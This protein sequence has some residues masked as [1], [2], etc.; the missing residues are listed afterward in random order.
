MRRD[1]RALHVLR[2]A[3]RGEEART[4]P[5]IWSPLFAQREVDGE[6][7]PPMDVLALLPDHRD[8]RQR[9]DAQRDQRRHAR[10]HREPGGAAQ[11]AGESGAAGDAPSRRSCAGSSPIIHFARTADAGRRAARQ[12]HPQG[13]RARRSSIRR[14]TATRRSSTDAVHVPRRPRP[15][16]PPRLRHRRALLPRLA[17]GAPR[18]RG[19]L[20]APAPAHRGDR[21][22][23][24]IERLHSALV[25]GVKHLPIRYKLRKS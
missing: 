2:E 4:R 13:R 14:R 9:D 24:P 8:R 21:A 11:G 23:G 16:P 18:A 7:L 12:A 15:E 19:R 6:P 25:G 10:V 20:Q 17:R 22:A 5:T 3:G 1:D